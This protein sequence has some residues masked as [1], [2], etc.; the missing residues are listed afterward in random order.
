MSAF[1]LKI[2]TVRL[3]LYGR[4]RLA[5]TGSTTMFGTLVKGPPVS[6]DKY[7]R[8]AFTLST[9]VQQYTFTVRSERALKLYI[10]KKRTHLTR[11][12]RRPR[13]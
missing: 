4:Y 6:V 7:K 2:V 13:H 3:V 10:E 12:F 9:R 11:S 1:F 8:V 5:G